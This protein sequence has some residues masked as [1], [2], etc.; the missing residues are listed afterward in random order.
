MCTRTWRLGAWITISEL[1]ILSVK[2]LKQ[3]FFAKAHGGRVKSDKR[4]SVSTAK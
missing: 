4:E 3:S 2:K 1:L